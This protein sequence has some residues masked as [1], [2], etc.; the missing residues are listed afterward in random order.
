[1]NGGAR[2]R[3]GDPSRTAIYEHLGKKSRERAVGLIGLARGDIR[4]RKADPHPLP[5]PRE[6]RKGERKAEI[7]KLQFTIYNSE[8]ERSFTT[9]R[10][11]GALEDLAC[12]WEFDPPFIPPGGPGGKENT[13]AER[14]S[15][16][17]W[18][19]APAGGRE[20]VMCVGVWARLEKQRGG[21]GGV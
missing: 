16:G 18:R 11:T 6:R 17:G 10:M 4:P 20:V 19:E 14:C 12:A 9:F 7:Y 2:G 8:A 3:S 15:W 5:F 13:E 21:A 1:M